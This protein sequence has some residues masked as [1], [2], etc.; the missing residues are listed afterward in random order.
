[1]EIS[2]TTW[3]KEAQTMLAQIDW[4]LKP[5]TKQFLEARIAGWG[6]KRLPENSS[7]LSQAALP[8]LVMRAQGLPQTIDPFYFALEKEKTI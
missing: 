5:E 4:Y 1:M 2:S 7:N 3:Q 8:L 6:K